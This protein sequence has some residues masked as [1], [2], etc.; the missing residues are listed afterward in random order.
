MRSTVRVGGGRSP[1]ALVAATFGHIKCSTNMNDKIQMRSFVMGAILGAI[2][3]IGIAA[4]KDSARTDWQYDTKTVDR[5][6]YQ[7]YSTELN[8]IAQ[9]G[10]EVVSAQLINF[11][12]DS[13]L[14]GL[15]VVLKRPRP[16]KEVSH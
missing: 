5:V 3:I 1:L 8:M 13:G 14:A 10:W 11:D 4:A 9:D 2:I 7:H 15:S 12:K 16:S 6:T